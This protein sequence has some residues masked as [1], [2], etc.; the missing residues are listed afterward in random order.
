MDFNRIIQSLAEQRPIFHSEDDFK[1]AISNVIKA[2]YPTYSLWLER[3]VCINMKKRDGTIKQERKAIDILIRDNN[4]NLIP[5]ELK[6]KTKKTKHVIIWDGE[7]YKLTNHGAPDIGRVSFRKDIYRIEQYLG[8]HI[9]K[10]NVGYVLIITND[11]EYLNDI[12]LKNTLNSNYSFCNGKIQAK[13]SGWNY[14]AFDKVKYIKE[15]ESNRWVY[16]NQRS[17][18]HW[19]Y[20]G[21]LSYILDLQNNYQIKWMQYPNG[22][23][24]TKFHYCLIEVKKD[25]FN[26]T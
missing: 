1:F 2:L 5:I 24:G 8:S 20:N 21:D 17:K 13:D 22:D 19:T 18:A 6:Y 26:N 7:E 4:K 25:T 10:A 12:S 15:I 11:G 14:D 16:R 3:P 9:K 23:I